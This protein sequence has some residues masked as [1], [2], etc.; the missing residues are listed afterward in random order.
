MTVV[1]A[2]VTAPCPSWSLTRGVGEARLRPRATPLHRGFIATREERDE[3][4]ARRA[5]TS[6]PPFPASCRPR[7]RAC[8]TRRPCR[9]PPRPDAPTRTN[10][11]GPRRGGVC[12][13]CERA[14]APHGRPFARS[15]TMEKRERRETTDTRETI[16]LLSPR[17]ARRGF[18]TTTQQM[19][20]R[21]IMSHDC[22]LSRAAISRAP[23]T[24]RAS[25]ACSRSRSGGPTDL[26]DEQVRELAQVVVARQRIGPGHADRDDRL[27]E[28][29]RCLVPARREQVRAR[30]RH[31]EPRALLVRRLERVARHAAR[32]PLERV[33]RRRRLAAAAARQ[34][35]P[36]ARAAAR[37]AAGSLKHD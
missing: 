1:P 4:G 31:L 14:R 11:R 3:L 8:R 35:T 21:D 6:C 29:A 7:S 10:S 28:V 15:T 25:L 5:R 32:A 22:P 27:V 19:F 24:R 26:G 36:P 34:E 37:H 18:N 12:G 30:A 33:R 23:P 17:R 2:R 13:L 20:D 16:Y 9:P